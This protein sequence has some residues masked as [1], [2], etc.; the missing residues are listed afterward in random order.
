VRFRAVCIV[1][2]ALLLSTL[3]CWS[4]LSEGCTH[5]WETVSVTEAT[6][7]KAGKTLYR[8]SL[9][10]KEKTEKI[11]ALGHDWALCTVVQVPTCTEDGLI[12]CTCSRDSSHVK[13]ETVPAP[14]HDWSP[15]I[16]EKE[17]TATEEGLEVRKCNVCGLTHNKAIPAT[18][19]GEAAMKATKEVCTI[20]ASL[21][22]L[23]GELTLPGG[24][25]PFPLVILSHG[26]GGNGMWNQDYADY[27]VS[28][29]FATFNFDF[30]GGGTGSRSDGALVQMSVLTEAQD[31][32]AILDTFRGDSRFSCI[33]LWGS[34]QG[35]FVSSYVAAKHPED[36]RAAV[37]EFPAYVLQDDAKARALPDGSF[38]ETESVMGTTIGGIYGKDATSFDIYDV[39]GG[40][41]GDVL[42]LHG[43]R[44]SIVPLRYSE[45]AAEVFPAAELIVMEGQGHGFM[46]TSRE[47]AKEKEGAFLL[48][49]LP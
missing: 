29:G 26:F 22:N 8:C 48:A 3:L 4:S 6:C 35:G 16:R 11:P 28:K 15:W 41:T 10:G 31:L 23:Y 46:G 39:I 47:E 17:P 45:R 38:P 34:S 42:L 43:D 36:I 30:C 49:H 44:D 12:R 7:E 24:E 14:G 18:G 32:E 1:L 27:F 9:C 40:Y 19:E 21:G 5:Q 33:F 25:G 20:P 37:L 2:L 13:E